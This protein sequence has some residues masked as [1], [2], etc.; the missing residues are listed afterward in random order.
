MA[1]F[2]EYA[3]FL[4]DFLT[5]KQTEEHFR[6]ML[7]P[8]L[9]ARAAESMRSQLQQPTSTFSTQD[10]DLPATDRLRISMTQQCLLLEHLPLF[11]AG[12]TDAAGIGKEI[13]ACFYMQ[14]SALLEA[15]AEEQEKSK[16]NL[17][18][19]VQNLEKAQEE[20]QRTSEELNQFAYTASHDLQ[21]P[22]RMIASYI[23]LLQ[24]RYK[25]KLDTTG[26][27]FI[28]FA[29][30]G[31]RRM[32]QLIDDL[33]SYSRAGRGPLKIEKV[34]TRHLAEHSVSELHSEIAQSG[35][36]ITLEE[37]PEIHADSMQLGQVFR[38]LLSNA[39]KFRGTGIPEIKI[40]C[41]TGNTHY[42]FSVEDNGIGIA[43]E[44]LE[45]IFVIF[46]RLHSRDEYPG[47]GIGLAICKKI[48][49]KHG[50]TIRAGSEP[51]KGSVF[52]FTVSKSL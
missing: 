19:A 36:R 40:S 27:E 25:D 35:A 16:Q 32:R 3:A 52:Y 51:G 33:L 29:V 8:P 47:T 39:L 17:E 18:K 2:K 5:D 6:K 44:F 49:E 41:T 31:T 12:S 28:E 26:N 9:I 21:E 4:A 15:I 43:G 13:G 24:R 45:R 34:S 10:P 11:K 48:V 30:D 20:A 1:G 50:G 22:L 38:H 42:L 7:P 14:Q 37:L 46:Q 23:Q